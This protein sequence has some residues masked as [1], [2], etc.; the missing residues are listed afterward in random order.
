LARSCRSAACAA[1]FAS[2]QLKNEGAILTS[3]RRG[4]SNSVMKAILVALCAVTAPL[5]A[6]KQPAPELLSRCLLGGNCTTELLAIPHESRTA[7]QRCVLKVTQPDAPFR[8]HLFPSSETSVGPTE[9]IATKVHIPIGWRYSQ[10]IERE[11]RGSTSGEAVSKPTA[12]RA[13]PR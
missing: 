6:A 7:E 11:E 8:V 3:I 4:S 10:C 13:G 2:P 9:V 5:L 1:Q 12:W